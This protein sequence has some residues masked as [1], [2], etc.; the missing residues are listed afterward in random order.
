MLVN[1]NRLSIK[2]RLSFKHKKRKFTLLNWRWNQMV[3]SCWNSYI[4]KKNYIC[5]IL[6]THFRSGNT[7]VCYRNKLPPVQSLHTSI[8]SSSR[9]DATYHQGASVMWIDLPL[10]RVLWATP[11][12]PCWPESSRTTPA[13][14]PPSNHA[15][16]AM[17]AANWFYYSQVPAQYLTLFIAVSLITSHDAQFALNSVARWC[18]GRTPGASNWMKGCQLAKSPA[19]RPIP[20]HP[21]HPIHKN[22]QTENENTIILRQK[23][24]I[25]YTHIDF[26]EKTSLYYETMV[27]ISYEMNTFSTT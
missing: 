11:Q 10:V 12:I 7:F 13:S 8:Y 22:T 27:L 16:R 20:H 23:Q 17:T 4:Y 3:K 21:L 25:I 15:A 5:C 2:A 6:E 26:I 14:V 19:A 18:T 24:C 1:N 9:L